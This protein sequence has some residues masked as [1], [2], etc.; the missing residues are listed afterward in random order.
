MTNTPK[1]QANKATDEQTVSHQELVLIAGQ[2]TAKRCKIAVTEVQTYS[3]ELPDAFGWQNGQ[4]HWLN[5]EYVHKEVGFIFTTLVEVKVSRSDFLRDLKK[6]H[7]RTL[8]M[9]NYR[10][11]CSPD[12]MIKPEELPGNWG[13]LYEKNG[14]IKS[15]KTA[16]FVESDKEAELWLLYNSAYKG[17]KI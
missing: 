9:G 1:P 14:K 10:Y 7:R 4:I 11:Y 8:G 16:K 5:D 17:K 13:L 3:T 12:N 2:W 6:P 15:I